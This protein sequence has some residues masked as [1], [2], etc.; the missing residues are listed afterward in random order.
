MRCQGVSWGR[1][2]LDPSRDQWFLWAASLASQPSVTV[3][4]GRKRLCEHVA[5]SGALSVGFL[6]RR[7]GDSSVVKIKVHRLHGMAHAQ[8]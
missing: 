6:S 5:A 1:H 2:E 3:T 4:I 7:Q 8:G